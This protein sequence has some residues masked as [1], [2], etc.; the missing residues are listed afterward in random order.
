MGYIFCLR[1]LKFT[2]KYLLIS[3]RAIHSNIWFLTN[4]WWS[5][6]TLSQSNSY[7]TKNLLVCINFCEMIE[8]LMTVRIHELLNNDVL[9]RTV[10]AWFFGHI[11]TNCGPDI[12][13][14]DVVACC[15]ILARFTSIN[16][17]LQKFFPFFFHHTCHTSTLIHLELLLFLR[18][19]R[20]SHYC[21]VIGI[22]V[23]ATDY[24]WDLL[25]YGVFVVFMIE[26]IFVAH[27]NIITNFH[28][29]WYVVFIVDD[30]KSINFEIKNLQ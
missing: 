1:F 2:R 21:L 8:C 17:L 7:I 16:K 14:S 28:S 26:V 29:T 24:C 9:W 20:F 22:I 5:F 27:C 10:V 18:F 25:C 19:N 6:K 12:N 23:T 4:L 15:R 11:F 3:N 30:F 13:N